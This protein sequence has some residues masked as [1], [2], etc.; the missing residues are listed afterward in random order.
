MIYI[1][2]VIVILLVVILAKLITIDVSPVIN[3]T[4]QCKHKE[5]EQVDY[6]LID[7]LIAD[8]LKLFVFPPCKFEKLEPIET[9]YIDYEKILSIANE[10]SE[11][12]ISEIQS[13]IDD[14]QI[15]ECRFQPSENPVSITEV[16]VAEPQPVQMTRK[17]NRIMKRLKRMQ[18]INIIPHDTD[19]FTG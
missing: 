3:T 10:T 14:I 5:P 13:S 12:I 19:V 9:V 4:V 2:V 16:K 7:K 6:Q 15:T 11:K 1:L 18:S 17:E 8:R